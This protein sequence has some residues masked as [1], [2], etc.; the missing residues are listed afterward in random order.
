ML[1]LKSSLLVEYCRIL[2]GLSSN[3]PIMLYHNML[4][5]QEQFGTGFAVCMDKKKRGLK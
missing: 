4:T 1:H 5:F 3:T 2:T